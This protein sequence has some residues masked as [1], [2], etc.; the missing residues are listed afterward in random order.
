LPYAPLLQADLRDETPDFGDCIS[1][2]TKHL[3][4]WVKQNNPKAY[5]FPLMTA[6]ERRLGHAPRFGAFDA[7]LMCMSTSPT[8]E[9]LPPF[10]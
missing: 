6:V 5:L 1:L 10:R 7:F 4:A 9:A 3:I 8:L 2:D